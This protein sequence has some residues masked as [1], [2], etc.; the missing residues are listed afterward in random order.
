MSKP[1]GDFD[2]GRKPELKELMR[3]TIEKVKENGRHLFFLQLANEGRLSMA[4]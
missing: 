2:L 4:E 1:K 3:I